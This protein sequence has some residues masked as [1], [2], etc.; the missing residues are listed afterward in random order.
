LADCGAG[1]VRDAGRVPETLES[2]HDRDQLS[3]TETTLLLEAAGR[4]GGVEF[5]EA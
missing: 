4:G 3:K 1:V 2:D 5:P